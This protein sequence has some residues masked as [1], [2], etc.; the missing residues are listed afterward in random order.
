MGCPV[1]KV[2]KADAGAKWLF[3]TM[4]FFLAIFYFGESFGTPQMIAFGCIWIAL[5][6]FSLSRQITTR[7]SLK[8]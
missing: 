3:P 7:I 4:G 5:V 2:T 1:P 6:L 8:K